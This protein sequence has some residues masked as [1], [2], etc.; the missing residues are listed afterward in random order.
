MSASNTQSFA[1]LPLLG[2]L[3]VSDEARAA[4]EREVLALFDRCAPSLQRYVSSFGLTA[5]ETEDVIQDV[6][7][8]LFHHLRLGRSRSHLK[9][10]LFQVAH[11]RALKLRSRIQRHRALACCD[12]AA[13]A[14][15]ADPA[16]GPESRLAEHQRRRRLLSV[17]NALP[18]R[19]RRCLILRAEGLGY[20]DI[21][22]A[23]GLSLGGV[24]KIVTRAIARL[25]SA[26]QR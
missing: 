24:A 18:E 20:R 3:D 19:D 9:G 8:S 23:L 5:E 7:L 14:A 6:F 17:V 21:A 10:W 16:P 2:S 12:D 25:A 15:Y 11:N 26:D 1:G 4:I 13:I 22:K